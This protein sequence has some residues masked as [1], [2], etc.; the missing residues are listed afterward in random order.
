MSKWTALLSVNF[1]ARRR[2]Q[3]VTR[4]NSCADRVQRL[5]EDTAVRLARQENK[6]RNF[7]R[8]NRDMEQ[9]P[10]ASTS[11][12]EKEA[13][14]LA[15]W[16][17]HSSWS[18]CEKC[19]LLCTTKLFPN[20]SKRPQ[21]KVQKTCSCANRRYVTPRYDQIPDE[22]KNLTAEEIQ[23]LRPLDVH[24][25]DYHR[26]QNGYRRKGG[27]FR[28]S[29]S[30]ISVQQ[31]IDELDT[32]SRTRCQTAY[33]F[34]M[35]SDESSYK[36]FVD[37]RDRQHQTTRFNLYDYD[38]RQGVEC[39]IWPHLYPFTSW[40][41]TTLD[42]RASRLSSKISFMTKVKSEIADYGIIHELL[43]FHYDLW[44]WQTVSGAIAQGKKKKCSPNRALE[45]KT[46]STEYWRWQHR[47]LINAVNQFG[48]P[49]LFITISP[50]EWT[51]P[52]PPWLQTLRTVTGH[53]PTSLSAYETI[54]IVNVLEQVVRGYLTGCNTNRWTTHVFHNNYK[55][56]MKNVST[57][58][59]RFE[60]QD[61]G[62]VH[63]HMLVWLKNPDKIK[64]DVFRADI[65]WSNERLA[66]LAAD[67]QHSDRGALP[68]RS[69][70]T[71]FT[72]RH[73]REV[74]SFF[75]PPEAFALNLRA[76]ISTLLPSL[77]CRMDVQS[78]DGRGMLLKYASSY[79]AKWHDAYDND[80]L[81]S[82]HVGPYQAA[83]RHL[84]ALTPLEPEMWMSLSSQFIAWTDSRTKKLTVPTR[85]TGTHKIWTLYKTRPKSLETLS[86]IQWMRLQ[87]ATSCS[88]Q[89]RHSV[90]CRYEDEKCF[91]RRVLLSRRGT[92]RSS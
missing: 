4:D 76:Y 29:W 78:S 90:T 54:H 1:W 86:L 61:R 5:D 13:H 50:F 26:A 60:F 11:F 45:D 63:L 18:Y 37:K 36:V 16:M 21:L 81:F 80:A 40:C 46:F 82:V 73:D 44:L 64:L 67:L 79:V 9:L 20:F 75:H 34:L 15:F 52:F 83:Y 91:L 58:F 69:D 10:E 49:D 19:K 59:Y 31:K 51:F 56:N 74:L 53:G 7:R 32:P 17:E 62:T 48:T 6:Q 39:C 70:K 87:Q 55:K 88:T 27:M 23:A 30:K 35:D 92:S 8:E 84:R 24:T 57:Y 65:P 33:D 14:D 77:K 2:W 66:F 43:H 89:R 85:Q 41:E 47:Y 71:A 25:G 68:Q 12:F 22:L 72:T 42:G 3:F 38:Q 28:L